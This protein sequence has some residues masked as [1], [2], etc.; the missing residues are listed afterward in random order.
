MNQVQRARCSVHRAGST[1]QHARCT[2]HGA[3]GT[4]GRARCTLHLALLLFVTGCGPSHRLLPVSLPD[5]TRSDQTVQQQARDRYA[6][7][8]RTIANRGAS[9]ADLA[10]AY[11]EY[12]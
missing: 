11:G 1:V 5:L 3:P 12:G 7:L 8:T 4:T 9:S 2:V 10:N 6:S